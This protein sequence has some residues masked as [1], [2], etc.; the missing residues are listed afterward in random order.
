MPRWEPDAVGRLQSAAFELFAEQGYERTTVAEITERA[1]LSKRTFF[2]H[3]TDKREVLFGPV[4]DL[5][6]EIVTRE[7]AAC[8][9]DL[10]PL[11]AAVRGLR[12]A[13][14]TLFE[15]RRDA[16]TRRREIIAANPE[17]E[18]RELR[19]RAALTDAIA[20]ALRAR[21][22]DTDTAFL[23]AQAGVLVHQAAMRRWTQSAGNRPLRDFLADALLSLRAITART[24]GSPPGQE[25]DS[26]T[27]QR[28]ASGPR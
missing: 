23:S 5:Q 16:V 10:P 8:P 24:A 14:D 7:I 3:F 18:E 19:K 6:Q 26:R 12:T 4:S 11:D 9:A 17:L 22:T 2:N 27:R 15:P 25:Q 13:A 1:G 20:E 21:G 28:P